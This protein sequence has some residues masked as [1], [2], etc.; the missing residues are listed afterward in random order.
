MGRSEDEVS[1]A[2]EHSDRVLDEELE[3][4]GWK[5]KKDKREVVPTVEGKRPGFDLAEKGQ[6]I[7]AGARHL[8]GR[9]TWNGNNLEELLCRKRAIR[10]AWL[11]TGRFWTV[12]GHWAKKRVIFGCKVLGAAVSAAETYAWHESEM[13]EINSIL[14]KYTRV[15]LRGRAKTVENGRVRQWSNQRLHEHWRIPP[16]SVEVAVRRVGWLQAMLRDG[17]NHAQLLAAIFG[18]FLGKD[19]LEEK[20][21]LY[22]GANPY[23][24]AFHRDVTCLKE[25]QAQ[26]SYTRLFGRRFLSRSSWHS[27]NRGR[28]FCE[29]TR[30]FFVQ[31]VGQWPQG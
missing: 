5:R 13:Q 16:V 3:G 7:V 8:G 20:G 2:L 1:E 29:L 21:G 28:F 4:G 17:R 31:L 9:S 27:L 12:K 26:R 6:G 11:S 14:C 19:V 25:S 15:M 18:R 22:E 30:L 10:T 23:A 24:V